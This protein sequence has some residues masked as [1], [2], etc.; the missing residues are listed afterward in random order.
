MIDFLYGFALA[1]QTKHTSIIVITNKFTRQIHLCS[2]SLNP[3]ASDTVQY[4][5]EMVVACHGLPRL[6]ISH[7][8]S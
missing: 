7:R 1:K 5:L 6:I 8:G 2:Y 4:F 3:T